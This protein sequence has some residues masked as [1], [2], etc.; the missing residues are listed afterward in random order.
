MSIKKYILTEGFETPNQL[1]MWKDHVDGLK[2]FNYPLQ[3]NKKWDA[4]SNTFD[5]ES[6]VEDWDEQGTPEKVELKDKMFMKGALRES[7]TLSEAY[8]VVRSKEDKNYV[9]YIPLKKGKASEDLEAI[10]KQ[11]K[12]TVITYYQDEA[13]ARQKVSDLKKGKKTIREELE[14][15]SELSR[16]KLGNYIRK[17]S[18]DVAQK[19][20]EMGSDG[21]DKKSAKKLSSRQH[22]I[23]K[24]VD[25]LTTE[26]TDP[27]KALKDKISKMSVSQLKT[28]IKKLNDMSGN[29]ED[30]VFDFAAKELEKKIPEKE[31]VKFMDSLD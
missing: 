27:E 3:N 21:Y 15:L 11:G 4:V 8:A 9:T 20:Y 17:A 19:G 2:I 7:E 18:K 23:G 31:F 26:T 13:K 24:A 6:W 25:R 1:K 5:I 12:Y 10:Q 22:N 30:T 28:I 29:D 16:E 14:E